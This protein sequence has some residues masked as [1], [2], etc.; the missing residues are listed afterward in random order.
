[1]QGLLVT[2]N[3]GETFS[4]PSE[5]LRAES[6]AAAPTTDLRGRPLIVHGKR[7]VGIYAI[8]PVGNYAVKLSFDDLHTSGVFSFDLLYD[9]GKN[10]Y[11]RMRQYL[12]LLKQHGLSRAP[13]PGTAKSSPFRS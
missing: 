9:I 3:N 1:M 12:T 2:F 11:R 7:N 8:E 10:K 6:P 13:P 5:L 4:L